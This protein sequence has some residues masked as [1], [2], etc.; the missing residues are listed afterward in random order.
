[1]VGERKKDD[2]NEDNDGDNDDDRKTPIISW[3]VREGQRARD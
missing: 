1:M 3:P 2:D